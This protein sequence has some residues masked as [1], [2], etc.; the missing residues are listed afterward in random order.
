MLLGVVPRVGPVYSQ[1]S[2][3]SVYPLAIAN[4]QENRYV[5]HIFNTGA[6]FPLLSSPHNE[7]SSLYKTVDHFQ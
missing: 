6:R 2:A 5:F 3:K 1:Q 7:T 4:C